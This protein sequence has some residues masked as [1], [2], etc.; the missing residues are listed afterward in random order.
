MAE[1]DLQKVIPVME[2]ISDCISWHLTSVYH[3]ILK[4]IY[5]DP[6]KLRRYVKMAINGKNLEALSNDSANYS[7]LNRIVALNLPCFGASLMNISEDMWNVNRGYCSFEKLFDPNHSRLPNMTHLAEDRIIQMQKFKS[8]QSDLTQKP[9]S[10]QPIDQ[11]STSNIQ[12]DDDSEKF[13]M[14]QDTFPVQIG[15]M[16]TIDS[17]AAD[18]NDC[19]IE[20]RSFT[21]SQQLHRLQYQNI[22]QQ[23]P[24]GYLPQYN[25]SQ[26]S[27]FIS[28]VPNSFNGLINRNPGSYS[29]Q[30]QEPHPS[31]QHM[32]SPAYFQYALHQHQQLQPQPQ[33]QLQPQS[34]PLPPQQQP[35]LHGFGVAGSKQLLPAPQLPH[36]GIPPLPIVGPHGVGGQFIGHSQ[37]SAD[38]VVI[39]SSQSQ[40]QSQS[41]SS[42]SQIQSQSQSTQGTQGSQMQSYSSGSQ[43]SGSQ[44]HG[45]AS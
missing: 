34:Q 17:Y 43:F 44:S 12:M 13:S 15:N 24:G 1:D 25:H 16:K 5:P 11:D 14:L 41:Q 29:V 40:S 31:N 33:P 22:H 35:Q 9:H 37:Q 39:G 28:T 30:T 8:H 36:G 7:L 2:E 4:E 3:F 21:S 26:G 42:Q 38:T 23:A 19:E 32:N 20:S 45:N 27:S 18:I 6:V 10:E